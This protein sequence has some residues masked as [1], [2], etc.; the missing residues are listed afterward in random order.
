MELRDFVYW[1]ILSFINERGKKR[2]NIAAS[3]YDISL[4][5]H[6]SF[7]GREQYIENA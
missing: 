2:P 6:C 3:W 1:E 5:I 4:V 7:Y